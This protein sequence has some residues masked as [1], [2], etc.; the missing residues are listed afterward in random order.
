MDLSFPSW[1][2]PPAA[3]PVPAAP[4]AG[5]SGQDREAAARKAA[6][7]FAGFFYGHLL[8][9]LRGAVPEGTLGR[10]GK[11]ERWFQELLDGTMG[12]RFAESDRTG[13]VETLYRSMAGPA[14]RPDPS[15][16]AEAARLSAV[17]P[18]ENR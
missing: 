6:T 15:G 8:K 17:S 5:L 14:P 11:G 2:P 7:G 12:D 4:A 16:A 1:A 13:L 18:L 3:A 10:G 9:T